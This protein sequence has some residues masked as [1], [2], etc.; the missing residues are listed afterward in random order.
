M[1]IA[2]AI[3]GT[4]LHSATDSSSYSQSVTVVVGRLY[5]V[6][7]ASTHASAAPVMSIAAT[8]ESFT[9][10]GGTNGFAMVSGQKRIQCFTCIGAAA[11]AKNFTITATNS[12]SQDIVV[13]EVTGFDPTTPIANAEGAAPGTLSTGPVVT[14]TAAADP[15]NRFLMSLIHNANERITVDSPWVELNDLGHNTP[16]MNQGT[17]WNPTDT[18]NTVDF[19]WT[20]NVQHA[21]I[22]VEIKAAPVT[23]QPW[24]SPYRQLLAQ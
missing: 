14:V 15:A 6:F 2:A 11:G 19:G 7:A 24:R 8:S 4:P 16:V 23:D 22:N 20:S 12:T 18:D 5:V 1:P 9:E 10:R 21:F 13:V 3:A 17:V